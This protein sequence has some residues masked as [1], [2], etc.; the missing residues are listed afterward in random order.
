MKKLQEEYVKT[1]WKGK[2]NYQK[3]KRDDKS[4]LF[5]EESINNNLFKNLKKSKYVDDKEFVILL[6][7][8]EK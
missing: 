7:K 5:G 4:I 6:D 8:L 1:N 3:L 2:K